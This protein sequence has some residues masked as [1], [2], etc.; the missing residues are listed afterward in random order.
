VDLCVEQKMLG[1]Q[2]GTQHIL[3]PFL[4]RTGARFTRNQLKNHWDTMIKQWKIWCRLVQCSDMQ[5][6]PQTNTFGANDQDWANY[7]HV[8][9][10]FCVDFG[11][12]LSL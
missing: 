12:F 2:P 6:D 8:Q 9:F 7:L 3:K 11:C 10:I 1:N 5:W 4:Q